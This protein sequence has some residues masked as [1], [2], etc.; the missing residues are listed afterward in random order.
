[1]VHRTYLES[2]LQIEHRCHF[3]YTKEGHACS[4]S[5]IYQLYFKDGTLPGHTKS[6]F[7]E[8]KILTVHTLHNII[9]FYS[10]L[11]KWR[12]FDSF[13]SSLPPKAPYQV[14]KYDDCESWLQKYNTFLYRNSI[15]SKGQCFI[16]LLVL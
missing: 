3:F 7:N 11:F 10:F 2:F 15:F 8:Y 9:D 1:M 6:A 13:P 16:L 4:N 14:L 5:R 12:R